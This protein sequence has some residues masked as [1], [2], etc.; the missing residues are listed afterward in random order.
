MPTMNDFSIIEEKI[1]AYF[2]VNTQ[3]LFEK[4]TTKNV[5]NARSY[6]LYILHY[7]YNVSVNKLATRYKRTRRNIHRFISN[8]KFYIENIKDSQ[9]EYEQIKKHIEK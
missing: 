2:N 7:D 4:Y 8:I 5:N 1:C 6:I 9:F 3:D